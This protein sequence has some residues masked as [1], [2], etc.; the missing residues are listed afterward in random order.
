MAGTPERYFEDFALGQR[1]V[2]TQRI[3]LDAARA[4]A[5]AEEFDPQPFH[6]DAS[7]AEQSLFRGLAVSG[8]LTGAVT[9]RLLVDG[10]L[11]PAGGILG[12]GIDELRWLRPVRADDEL[13]IESEVIEVSAPQAGRQH[14]SVRV[15]TLTIN[16]RDETVM[17][18]I[19]N[20][21]VPVRRITP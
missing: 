19:A 2:G 12:A 8:W 11:K 20:L 21:R 9:M 13:R 5:F 3:R 17:S 7:A 10:D 6:L 18:Y 14:G 16:Q 4:K 1:V 15:R